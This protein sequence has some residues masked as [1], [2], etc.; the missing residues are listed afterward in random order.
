MVELEAGP[1]RPKGKVCLM[2]V[3]VQYSVLKTD[4]LPSELREDKRFAI[5]AGVASRSAYG[6]PWICHRRTA[7]SA[8]QTSWHVQL[9]VSEL[10]SRRGPM[11]WV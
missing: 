3:E 7:I 2:H 5:G 4:R 11:T 1:S 10:Q 8:N 6:Q 9:A